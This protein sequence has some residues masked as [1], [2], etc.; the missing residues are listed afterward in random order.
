[1]CFLL[2]KFLRNGNNFLVHLIQLEAPHSDMS[3]PTLPA[4]DVISSHKLL[5]LTVSTTPENA[6]I[7]FMNFLEYEYCDSQI[8]VKSEWKFC[9]SYINMALPVMWCLHKQAA[10]TPCI[11]V[12]V[13]WHAALVDRN[14]PPVHF[15]YHKFCSKEIKVQD[16]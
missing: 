9:P 8:A 5:W 14:M 7:N 16:L 2:D 13:Q 3:Y 1:M 4:L 15:S 10:S 6:S 11:N 12:R